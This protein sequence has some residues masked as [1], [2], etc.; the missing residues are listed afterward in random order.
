MRE[1]EK[2][3]IREIEYFF[4]LANNEREKRDRK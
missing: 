4:C 1:L 2:R 3:V